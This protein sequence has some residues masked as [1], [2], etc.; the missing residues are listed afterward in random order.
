[1]IGVPPAVEQAEQAEKKAG[2]KTGVVQPGFQSDL[3]IPFN[4][5]GWQVQPYF[6]ALS[7]V[8][9]KDVALKSDPVAAIR[10]ALPQGW[11]VKVEDDTYPPHRAAGKGKAILLRPS[12]R[13]S[14]EVIVY[15]MPSDYQD[16]ERVSAEVKAPTSHP[17]SV[18]AEVPP[19]KVYFWAADGYFTA[20]GWPTVADDILKAL[21]KRSSSVGRSEPPRPI[22]A[23][24]TKGQL[25]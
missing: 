12:Y 23:G 4:Q 14:A 15:L 21:L 19:F 13:E 10:S 6:A 3:N 1:M 24:V 25:P 8:A 9:L 2:E 17:A 5:A 11:T 18:I 22:R 7:P 20:S 16:G